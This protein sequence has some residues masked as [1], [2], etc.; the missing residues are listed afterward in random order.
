MQCRKEVGPTRKEEALVSKNESEEMGKRRG[1]EWGAKHRELVQRGAENG[2]LC[3][4]GMPTCDC[5]SLECTTSEWVALLCSSPHSFW[6]FW[7]HRYVLARVRQEAAPI[8]EHSLNKP[9]TSCI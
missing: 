2:A 7:L 6:S 5:T 1:Q 3:S 8:L 9:L 4:R